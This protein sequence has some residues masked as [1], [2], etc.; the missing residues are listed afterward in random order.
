MFHHDRPESVQGQYASLHEG[1][2][3]LRQ[4]RDRMSRPGRAPEIISR[5]GRDS[6]VRWQAAVTIQ[7]MWRGA[8]ARERAMDKWVAIW[9]IQRF[10]RGALVRY[11]MARWRGRPIGPVRK[12]R[13]ASK[14]AHERELARQ[15]R[16]E[17]REQRRQ[18]SEKQNAE[19]QKLLARVESVRR[20]VIRTPSASGTPRS[21]FTGYAYS[22]D[23]TFGSAPTEVGEPV[24]P[25]ALM[26][27]PT[28]TMRSVDAPAIDPM[29]GQTM[30]V[31]IQ[32]RDGSVQMLPVMVMPQDS[33]NRKQRNASVEETANFLMSLASDK[34]ASKGEVESTKFLM[35]LAD[36]TLRLPTPNVDPNSTV[37]STYIALE[38]PAKNAELGAT[39][40]TPAKPTPPPASVRKS[41][42]GSLRGVYQR[43]KEKGLVEPRSSETDAGAEERGRDSFL[44][45]PAGPAS[46]PPS[47]SKRGNLPP[48]MDD[49]ASYVS[50]KPPPRPQER[51]AKVVEDAVTAVK[52][53]DA[54]RGSGGAGA[55]PAV[56][57]AKPPAAPSPEAEKIAGLQG[58]IDELNTVQRKLLDEIHAEFPEVAA[59][60]QRP[61]RRI[62]EGASAPAA[63]AAAASRHREISFAPTPSPVR[64]MRRERETRVGEDDAMERYAAMLAGTIE[65][66]RE[67]GVKEREP[68]SSHQDATPTR[69]RTSARFTPASSSRRSSLGSVRG[70]AG[71]TPARKPGSRGAPDTAAAAAR[72][73]A[74]EVED[75]EEERISRR[76][77]QVYL[78][79]ESRT[80]H[81]NALVSRYSTDARVDEAMDGS[82]RATSYAVDSSVPRGTAT[83]FTRMGSRGSPASILDTL[84]SDASDPYEQYERHSYTSHKPAN[85]GNYWEIRQGIAKEFHSGSDSRPNTHRNLRLL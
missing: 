85:T 24:T 49:Y 72:R 16:A 56:V 1:E 69:A 37:A 67:G 73:R 60:R 62:A 23:S 42:P 31:P 14:R 65:K 34:A 11:R 15:K 80:R 68:M 26:T 27:T 82:R 35:E 48:D 40:S 6:Y 39:L 25:T 45:V 59:A 7:K 51:F 55:K 54:V 36:Q 57:G 66:E 5:P 9:Q 4:A 50:P 70:S 18:E 28:S 29:P 43:V 46:A 32:M 76:L 19:V 22:P 77:G 12:Q 44:S 13:A 33:P 78:A 84:R 79:G 2:T 58:L 41:H 61:S 30:E 71:F 8:L 75:E 53:G 38:S 64:M 3:L 21:S 74:I 83:R 17:E 10:W 52:V 63:A 81:A 20:G 47:A